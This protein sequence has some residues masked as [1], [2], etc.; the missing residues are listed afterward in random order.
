[1]TDTTPSPARRAFLQGGLAASLGAAA[2]TALASTAQ[3]QTQAPRPFTGKVALVTG[4]ARGIG[5][6]IAEDYARL[7]ASV[8]MID[9]A[10]PAA[11]AARPGFRVAT[12]GEFDEAAAAVMRHGTRVLKIRADVRDLAAMKAAADRTARELGGIDF[13]VANAGFVAWHTNEAGVE[14]DFIDVVDVNIHGVWK[15]IQPTIAHLKARG[16][17]RI[18]TLA[19]I[20][21]RAGFAGN[22]IYTATKWAVIG[23]TKQMAQEFGPANIAVN[24]VSPGPVN[25]PMYR[26]E[27]QMASMGG[28]TSAA[29]QDAALNPL[30]P[31]GDRPALEPKDIADAVMFLSSEQARS[32]S[33][34]ALDVALGFN[35]SYTA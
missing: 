32:I 24:A 8:A 20:G 10:N 11:F 5:R 2:A 30:L 19:S 9:V 34:V 22:G 25:T 6:A 16:G 15:T 35:A 31:L 3:A 14:Q 21:G 26:S 1:M 12:M 23:L 4:A 29:Q 28:M 18:I 7:G 27:A 33:G 13:V 17:G